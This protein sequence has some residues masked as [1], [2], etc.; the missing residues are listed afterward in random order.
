MRLSIPLATVLAIALLGPASASAGTVCLGVDGV[1]TFQAADVVSAPCGGAAGPGEIN[2]LTVSANSAGDI[3]FTDSSPI[4]DGD[5]PGGCETSDKTAT[6]PGAL[7]YSFSLGDQDDTATVGAVAG[8][9]LLSTGGD[10]KD[11]L[12][13]GALGDVLDGGPGTDVIDAGDGDDTLS[14]GAGNDQLTGGAGADELHGGDGVDALDGGAGP[15]RLMGGAGDDSEHGGEGNDALD[16]GAAAGCVESA[17]GDVLSGDDGD[18]VLCGGA[19]P[20]A[21]NDNDVIGGGSGEDAVY[22]VRAAAVNVSLDG[23]TG[24]GQ[25]GEA[26]NVASDVEDATGGSGG[27]VLTGNDGRNV[28]DGG[29]GGDALHG[30]GGNDVLIDSGGDNAPD[31]LDGGA[32]DDAMAAGAGAD[33]YSGGDGEDAVTDYA[34]RSFPGGVTLDNNADDGAPGEGDNV[35]ANVEDVT[36]GAGA[37]TLVGNDADNELD[38][39]A[40]DDALA[41][42]GG[43]DG[44]EGGAGRDTVD[45]GGGRDDLVGGAGA[46]TLKSRDGLTDRLNCNGGTDS[47]Q[48]E[49]RDDIAGNCENVSIAPPTAVAI[50]SVTV[51][52]AGLVVI[53]V[54]CPAVERSCAGAIIVKTVRRV[55]RR[56]IKLGQVNY[57][58]RGA[59]NKVFKAKIAAKDR[60]ALRRARRVKVRTVV[61]NANADTG[62]STNATSLKTVTTRGLR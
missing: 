20:A 43:N 35:M 44:L 45:G 29:P 14:G 54:G 10:G 25:G 32:G 3:V 58:L 46:D 2:A 4:A 9:G 38:G 28:L 5:G 60:K 61:T 30:M 62:D 53:R 23:A 39:G 18:D 47:V 11:H 34:G 27:D 22:Y 48:G 1:A 40:G 37:D 42:G 13:G 33:V 41:G 17:G 31:S 50:M 56:F 15:D 16:G 24:D 55:A 57:R 19:G 52:R 8:G 36:G 51:T 49:A 21:G 6:C 59:Q 7:S 26:D 12:I